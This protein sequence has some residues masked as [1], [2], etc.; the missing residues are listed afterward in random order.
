M[1]SAFRGTIYEPYD[2]FADCTHDLVV[3]MDPLVAESAVLS[4][5]KLPKPQM[6][7]LAGAAEALF[8]QCVPA[9]VVLQRIP[10]EGFLILALGMKFPEALSVRQEEQFTQSLLGWLENA[11]EHIRGE[12]GLSLQLSVSA[13]HLHTQNVYD[14]YQEAFSVAAHAPFFQQSSPVILYRDFQ[15]GLSA[16]AIEEKKLLE[17]QFYALMNAQNY[18]DAETLLVQLT[19]LR[20]SAPATVTSLTQEL[21]SRMEFFAYQL[22]DTME[23][24]MGAQENLL[25][26]IQLIHS[27]KNMEEL[28]RQ[29]HVIFTAMD[30]VR[31]RSGCG[32]D[33]GWARKIAIYIQNN[34]ADP[35][36]NAENAS[37]QFGMNPSYISHIFH[38]GTGIK[39]LDYIHLT[40]IEHIKL[41]LRS[42]NMSLSDM[43]RRTGYIDRYSMSRVFRRYVGVTPS[44]YRRQP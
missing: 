34:Y 33:L 26:E 6:L 20:A 21:I 35:N 18:Q 10:V 42:T 43:A 8:R 32:R 12:L 38:E 2:F 36:L 7:Q 11:L 14:A 4:R 40:R 16:S 39:L 3:H 22:C 9:S 23:L 27:A 28:H 25:R 30:Q 17:K 44:E 13:L 5:E 41:L 31:S 19:E 1:P 37:R 24:P 15:N 29:I